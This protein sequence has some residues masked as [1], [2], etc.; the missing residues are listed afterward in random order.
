MHRKECVQGQLP[1]RIVQEGHRAPALRSAQAGLHHD[2]R[3]APER[4]VP[5]KVLAASVREDHGP[6]GRAPADR[7][8]QEFRRQSPGSRFTRAS[9]PRP[10]GA[11]SLRNDSR[12]ASADS[13]PCGRAREP[14]R[15]EERLKPSRSLRFSANRV[16]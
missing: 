14:A 15:A 9:R 2:F 13:I 11:R 4:D 5:G 1:D 3:N 12:K 16:R 6:E 8:V 10:A 7:E